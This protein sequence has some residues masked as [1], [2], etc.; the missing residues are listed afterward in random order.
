[1]YT[2]I[3]PTIGLV[4]DKITKV[5]QKSTCRWLGATLLPNPSPTHTPWFRRVGTEVGTDGVYLAILIRVKNRFSD[6]DGCLESGLVLW[7]V[8]NLTCTEYYK[9]SGSSGSSGRL[10]SLL[11]T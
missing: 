6:C 4:Q 8:I 2:F 7:L 10:D 11:L 9:S 1:M 3:C 5:E